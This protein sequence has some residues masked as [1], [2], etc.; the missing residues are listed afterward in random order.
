M[1]RLRTEDKLCF[2]TS[3]FIDAKTDE[4]IPA[5]QTNQSSH[6]IDVLA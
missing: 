6:P 3:L 4:L 5:W 1:W 2:R